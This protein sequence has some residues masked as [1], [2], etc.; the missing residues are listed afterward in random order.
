MQTEYADTV[1]NAVRL[2]LEALGEIRDNA[3][4]FLNKDFDLKKK[5]HEIGS[6]NLKNYL[7]LVRTW[8]GT[9]LSGFQIFLMP[10]SF[11]S[12]FSTAEAVVPNAEERRI[13]EYM[14]G[15][16]EAIDDD[17]SNDTNLSLDIAVRLRRTSQAAAEMRVT[18][19]PGAVEVQLSEEDV[20]DKYPWD[21]NILTTRLRNRYTDFLANQKY[22]DLRR[23]L[24]DDPNLCRTR[25]LDP[26]NTQ[27]P[28]KKFYSPN[29][30]R[31]FDAHYT[32]TGS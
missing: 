6:A 15:L 20:R 28:T 21:Y 1:P 25:Y 12:G 4:H 11:V 27:S 16:E 14:R 19:N 30:M 31:E 13:L 24:E 8:F 7:F 22:H 2:N 10:I 5:I 9:D 29:I 26:G 17:V 23:P 32:R 18:N 3:V